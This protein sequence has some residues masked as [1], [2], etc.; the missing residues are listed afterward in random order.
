MLH[1]F[2]KDQPSIPPIL[3][4][5]E[6]AQDETGLW[7]TQIEEADAPLFLLGEPGSPF[8]MPPPAASA[9][10]SPAHAPDTSIVQDLHAV[11][12]K[13]QAEEKDVEQVLSEFARELDV[14]DPPP[15]VPS[16]PTADAK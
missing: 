4:G 7:T 14:L 9:P 12:A 15:Q 3:H 2:T 5:Y 11:V 1:V 13:L 8:F 6:F 16:G 10:P